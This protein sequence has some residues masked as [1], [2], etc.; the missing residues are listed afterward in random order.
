MMTNFQ[1]GSPLM[2]NVDQSFTGL[3]L[4]RAQDLIK[5]KGFPAREQF[6]SD[7]FFQQAVDNFRQMRAALRD[8][9]KWTTAGIGRN[10]M[11]DQSVGKYVNDGIFGK[12]P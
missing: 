3:S 5:G 12:G 6:T 9:A 2:K 4:S 8:N 10:Y 11:I 7:A 1:Q